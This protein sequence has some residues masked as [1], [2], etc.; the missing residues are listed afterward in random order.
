M[1]LKSAPLLVLFVLALA[2]F[3]G[4]AQD[5]TNTTSDNPEMQEQVMKGAGASAEAGT[6]KEDANESNDTTRTKASGGAASGNKLAISA[7]PTGALKFN[8]AKLNAEAGD[9]TVA[10]VNESA[11]THDVT[12]KGS[13][14]AL[15]ATDQ[16]S[17]DNA[18]LV[19]K[20]VKPGSYTFFCSIPGHEE[21]GMKGTLTVR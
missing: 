16:I 15:G 7:D 9:I 21:A 2:V 4:C 1:K 14:K 17:K 13:G 18:K 19:L 20:D 12:F 10:F 11:T 5:S 8:T 6:G 3:A